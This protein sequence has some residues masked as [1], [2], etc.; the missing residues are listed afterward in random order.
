MERL[1]QVY[2]PDLFQKEAHQLV[3]VLTNHFRKTQSEEGKVM[4]WLAPNEQLDFWN[5]F[6]EN[7][8]ENSFSDFYK[9]ILEKSINIHRKKYVGHQVSAPSFVSLLS[10][11][12]STSLNNG[13]AVYEMGASASA[14]EQIVINKLSSKLNFS[15]NS[16]GILTS[17]GTLANLTALLSAR[18]RFEKE[19]VQDLLFNQKMALFV[20]EQA[21]YCVERAAKVMGWGE[22]GIIK[23][24]TDDTFRMRTDLLEKYLEEAKA[25]NIAIVAVVGS[26]CTTSTGTYDDLEAIGQFC[27][28]HKIWFHVDGAHGGAVAFSKKYNHLLQGVEQADSITIDF[29]K[30]LLCPAL[31]T[32]LVYKN[33]EDSYRTFN[34][35][36]DY[37]LD[38]ERDWYNYGKRTFECTKLMMSLHPFLLMKFFGEEVFEENVNRLYDQGKVLATLI[39]ETD[40]FELGNQ[41]DANIVCFRYKRANWTDD[42]TSTINTAIRQQILEEGKFYIVQTKLNGNVYLRCTVMN[43]FTGETEFRDLLAYIEEILFYKNRELTL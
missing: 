25:K 28:K 6:L 32:A 17:G 29:H 13:M 37:L 36:A 34:Q 43:P 30:M 23:I 14:I 7:D 4:N 24:P 20:S 41:P 8:M 12:I 2:N 35:T 9:N 3:D 1:R 42:K 39:Q 18:A 31:C 22:A 5:G 11:M 10:S 33:A 38:E 19:K 21:H 15:K 27:D 16:S 26:A 40:N